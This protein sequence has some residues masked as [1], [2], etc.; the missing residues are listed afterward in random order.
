MPSESVRVQDRSYQKRKGISEPK[1]KSGYI[2]CI[3]QG[4]TAGYTR[5]CRLLSAGIFLSAKA[6]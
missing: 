6:N 4:G 3:K 5:P 2:F 1:K